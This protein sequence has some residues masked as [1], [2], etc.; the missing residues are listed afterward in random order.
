MGSSADRRQTAETGA[1]A[2]AR[3]AGA[4]AGTVAGTPVRPTV[5]SPLRIRD[6]DYGGAKPL[7]CI[8]LV[9]VDL[10]SLT[11]QAKTASAL[12]PDLVEWRADFF[13]E[14]TPGALGD[15]ARLLR[16]I[17]MDTAVIFTLRVK[18]EGGAQDQPQPLRARLIEAVLR[19][20]TVDIV[21]LELA[22]DA[23]M[24]SRLMAIARECGVRVLLAVHNFDETPPTDALLDQIRAME[25]RGADIAKFAVM[26]RSRE[27]VLRVLQVTAMARREFPDLPLATMAMGPLGVVSRVA[28]FLFGS[29]M[30]FAVGK[31]ASAPGQIPIEE[32]RQMTDLLLRYS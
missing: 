11:D 14:A 32:A 29:D 13:R 10:E 25:A 15:A 31:T 30:A 21:D 20:G 23:A 16:N 4:R 1:N 5:S 24:L 8:P 18:H 26:P 9:P 17:V 27:D 2:V 3:A 28:G 12:N 19:S 22:T 6:I 7:F